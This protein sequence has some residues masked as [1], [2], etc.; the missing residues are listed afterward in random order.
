MTVAFHKYGWE[1][2][3]YWQQSDRKVLKRINT[4]IKDILR[5]PLDENGI[6]KPEKLKGDLSGCFSRRITEEHRL[7]Y[8]V[9]EDQTIILQCRFHYSK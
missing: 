8:K 2:Y 1:D 6:G 7:V 4:L 5:N 3:L 9:I